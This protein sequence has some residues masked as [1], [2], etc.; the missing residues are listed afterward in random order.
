MP[1]TWEAWAR[2]ELGYIPPATYQNMRLVTIR[3]IERLMRSGMSETRIL[4]SYNG[5]G[6]DGRCHAG[7]NKYGVRFDSCEYA[8]RVQAITLN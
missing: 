5:T 3:R 8:L 6:R 4:W 2:E 7:V 1:S